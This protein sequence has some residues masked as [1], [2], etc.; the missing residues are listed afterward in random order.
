MNIMSMGASFTIS[1]R[2]PSDMTKLHD[3]AVSC[4]SRHSNSVFAAVFD[5]MD[6]LVKE[7]GMAGAILRWGNDADA[8]SLCVAYLNAVKADVPPTKQTTATVVPVNGSA[9]NDRRQ[10]VPAAVARGMRD[11]S[12]DYIRVA[13]RTAKSL[14]D[15]FKTSAGKPWGDVCAHELHAYRRDGT[16]AK[17]FLDAVEPKLAHAKDSDRTK[18]LREILTLDEFEA[19]MKQVKA[20]EKKEAK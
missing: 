18:P 19:C 13:V 9:L 1:E 16:V 15:T 5:F 3:F 2:A 6:G 8:Y 14:Y 12:N 17:V 11:A 10:A 7:G 4:L 20:K